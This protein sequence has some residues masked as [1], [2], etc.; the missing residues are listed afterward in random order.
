MLNKNMNK[1]S[2]KDVD[3]IWVSI[4]LGILYAAKHN[5]PF[6]RIPNLT[7]KALSTNRKTKSPLQKDTISISK[8]CQEL[9]KL[10]KENKDQKAVL[11]LL[12]ERALEIRLLL[13]KEKGMGSNRQR[14]DELETK[15]IVKKCNHKILTEHWS[16][17][18]NNIVPGYVEIE[19]S[20]SSLIL[21]QNGEYSWLEQSKMLI[22]ISKLLLKN[23]QKYI[24]K[25]KDILPGK[26]SRYNISKPGEKE[27]LL[28]S[29]Q[30]VESLDNQLIMD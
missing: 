26:A 21:E 17:K 20:N 15:K 22:V 7:K 23:N 24:L 6:R 14:N 28:C 25:Y 9:K 13:Q 19:K 11:A 27:S 10:A 18:D 12:S 29:L 1:I 2:Q 3:N 16:T 5:I 4:E 8:I 30:S